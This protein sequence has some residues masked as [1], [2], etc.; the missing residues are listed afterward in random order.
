MTMW[1]PYYIESMEIYLMK[2]V[3][4]RFNLDIDYNMW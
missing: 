3:Y 1:P 4:E 2:N